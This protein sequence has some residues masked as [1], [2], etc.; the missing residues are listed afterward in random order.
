MRHKIEAKIK[1]IKYYLSLLEEYKPECQKRFE[2]DSMFEGALMHYLI[3][4]VTAVLR[5]PK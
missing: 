1:R 5:L 2:N 3:L 4:P